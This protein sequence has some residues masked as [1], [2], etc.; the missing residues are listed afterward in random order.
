MRLRKELRTVRG[1]AGGEVANL[2]QAERVLRSFPRRKGTERMKD[3]DIRAGVHTQ[4]LRS[5]HRDPEILVV[6]ELGLL[7]GQNRADIAVIGDQLTGYEIKGDLDSL[8]RLPRQIETYSAVFDNACIV[9]GPR[10]IYAA[11]ASVPDW[12]GVILAWPVDG[13][14]VAVEKVRDSLTNPSVQPLA[15]AHLLWR[16]EA[17]Q[18][19]SVQA[20]VSDRD[21][22]QSRMFLYELLVDMLSLSDLRFHVSAR[23]RSR[24]TW[25]CRPRLSR[26]VGLC[27]RVSKQ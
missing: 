11:L 26:G 18:I 17:I 9:A 2:A 5:Q 3:R 8:G 10:L 7:H 1:F 27:R 16:S 6:D 12:W 19:L 4:V 23:L 21:L 24:E 14:G 20:G 13:G 22:R 25:G 15:L